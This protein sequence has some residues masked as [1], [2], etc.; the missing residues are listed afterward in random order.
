MSALFLF[1]CLPACLMLQSSTLRLPVSFSLPACLPHATSRQH[2]VGLV[3]FCRT[4]CLPHATSRELYVCLFLFLY[5][6]ACPKLQSSTLCLPVSFSMPACLPHATSR[7]L[8]VCLFLF[9]CLP[10]CLMLPVVKFMSACFLSSGL[11]TCLIL[12]VALT[13]C[14]FVSCLLA[15]LSNAS[16]MFSSSLPLHFS[17]CLHAGLM[18]P[19]C[20]L[21]I[22]LRLFL[23]VCS[24]PDAFLS[25]S[26]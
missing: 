17:D 1:L 2:Y 3:S 21:F 16:C 8:Y 23:F 26:T 19:V 24:L 20:Q 18:L 15:C 25:A 12:P 4:A 22:F 14:L 5:L 11:P 10:A 9:L 6:P 7:E 13:L